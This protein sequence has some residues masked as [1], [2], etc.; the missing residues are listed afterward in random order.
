MFAIVARRSR[1]L[2][3]IVLLVVGACQGSTNSQTGALEVSA[4]YTCAS[5]LVCDSDGVVIA[6]DNAAGQ[7][8]TAFADTFVGIPVGQHKVTLSDV[9]SSCTFSGSNPRFVVVK[10]DTMVQA[11]W[12]GTCQ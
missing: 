5:Q 4:S 6:L 10:A 2:S 8:M 11:G 9:Q 7:R 3:L 12:A 1:V